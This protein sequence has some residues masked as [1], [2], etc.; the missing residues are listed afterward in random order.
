MVKEDSSEDEVQSLP[1]ESRLQTM[2]GKNKSRKIDQAILSSGRREAEKIKLLLLGA[3]KSTFVK[4]MRI[5]HTQGYPIEERLEY[6]SVVV[7]NTIQSLAAILKAMNFLNIAFDSPEN[8]SRARVFL[9]Q[10][11][12][13]DFVDVQ[14]LPNHLHS[15]MEVLWGDQGVRKSFQR[16]K[17]YQLNDSAPYFLD[18]LDRVATEDYVPTENDILRTRVKTTTISEIT[19]VFKDLMFCMYD[20]GGQRTERR[21]WIHCFDNVTSVFFLAAISAYDQTLEEDP[22][23]NRLRES[24]KLFDSICNN[25]WFEETSMVLFLNKTDLFQQKI[26]VNPLSN[27]FSDFPDTCVDFQDNANYV[28]KMFLDKNQSP[29]TIYSHFTCATDTAN[30]NVVF[31]TVV[32]IIVM[33]QLKDINMI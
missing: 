23:T 29:R 8:E 13:M 21:K 18:S 2:F 6:R 3:G 15:H 22:T 26:L 5:L 19:F 11:N 28:L 30:V 33:H 9:H 25:R 32:D 7:A 24:V 1:Q 4:Q 31:T 17:E 20:V 14:S 12:G 27:Y 10:V 16:S